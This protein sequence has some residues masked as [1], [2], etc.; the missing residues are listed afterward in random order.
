VSRFRNE[1]EHLRAH[2]KSLRL[3]WVAL[4]AVAVLLGLG[5][6]SAPKHLTIHVPPDL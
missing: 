4:F 5:W 2:V 1:I 3:G 6:W